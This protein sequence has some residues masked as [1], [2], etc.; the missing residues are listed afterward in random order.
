ML[1]YILRHELVTEHI[2]EHVHGLDLDVHV[3]PV[4]SSHGLPVEDAPWSNSA[5]VGRSFERDMALVRQRFVERSRS[6]FAFKRSPET[7]FEIHETSLESGSIRVCN[8][9]CDDILPEHADIH[10]A[11]QNIKISAPRVTR[12]HDLSNLH[13]PPQ[14]GLSLYFGVF[15][16]YLILTE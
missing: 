8:V 3:I 14:Q 11:L 6:T 16:L 2:V 10:G 1:A 4:I 9:V 13:S 15:R 5:I 12:K 7:A